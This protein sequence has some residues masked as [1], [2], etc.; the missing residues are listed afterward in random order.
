MI[1][2]HHATRPSYR[3]RPTVGG[4]EG[5]RLLTLAGIEGAPIDGV[6]A[7]FT[8]NNLNHFNFSVLNT[9]WGDNTN[10]SG[11]VVRPNPAGGGLYDVVD[12]HVYKEQGTYGISISLVYSY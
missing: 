10:V 12:T 2:N 6:I 8:D 1:R 11:A 9:S 5:R 3:L 4:L 7:T